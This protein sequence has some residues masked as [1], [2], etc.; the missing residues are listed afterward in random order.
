MK[1]SNERLSNYHYICIHIKQVIVIF[2][3]DWIAILGIDWPWLYCHAV[4]YV[5]DED[6][7]H[8]IDTMIHYYWYQLISNAYWYTRW[9]MKQE[10]LAYVFQNLIRR[11]YCDYI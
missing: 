1:V 5:A 4:H 8:E 11:W 6:A 7:E 2:R 3:C 9:Q 10:T